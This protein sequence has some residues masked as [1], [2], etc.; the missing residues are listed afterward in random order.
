[1]HGDEEIGSPG[2]VGMSQTQEI[3]RAVLAYPGKDAAQIMDL[4]K[5]VESGTTC[6]SALKYL[7]D[8][9]EI[10][11]ARIDGRF[12]YWPPGQAPET[13]APHTP[14][15]GYPGVNIDRANRV[16]QVEAKAAPKAADIALA[17]ISLE[18]VAKPLNNGNSTAIQ[19]QFSRPENQLRT[20]VTDD[21]LIVRLSDGSVLLNRKETDTGFR[22]DAE[23]V[24]AI[25]EMVA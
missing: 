3:L 17:E 18:P 11:R 15:K 23:T 13:V 7:T 9:G 21:W 10:S 2:E 8:R 4:A 19:R 6:A 12:C 22:L 1:M 25:K 20:A 5:G 24:A 16:A 14:T